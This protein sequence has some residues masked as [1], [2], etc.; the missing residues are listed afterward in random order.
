[1][2]KTFA[3]YSVGGAIQYTMRC[4][5]VHTSLEAEIGLS[6]IEVSDNVTD[7]RFY[8]ANGGAAEKQLFALT[9]NKLQITADGTDECVI[10]N[11]PTGTTIEW[12]DGQIGEVT[13]GEVRF[14][15]DL[16]GTYTLKFTAVAYLDKE[17][18]IE[19][20]PAA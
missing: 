2:S 9:I 18:T 14:A 16:P 1:M 6:V 10:T 3:A 7:S 11:I 4:A 20:L 19:A 12:P 15:V 8:I 5:S 13:D 17:V